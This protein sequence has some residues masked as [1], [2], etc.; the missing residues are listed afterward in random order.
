VVAVRAIDFEA[1]GAGRDLQAPDPARD[2]RSHL[3]GENL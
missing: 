2:R 3:P 1:A